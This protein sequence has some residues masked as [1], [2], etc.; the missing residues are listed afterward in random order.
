MGKGNKAAPQ[1]SAPKAGKPAKASTS[2]I[3]DELRK[4]VKDLGGDDSDLELIAGVDSDDESPQEAS[5]GNGMSEVGYS[6]LGYS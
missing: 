6:T 5:K 4:A 3:S 2:K 1:K